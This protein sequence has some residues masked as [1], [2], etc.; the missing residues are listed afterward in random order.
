[1]C[2]RFVRNNAVIESRYMTTYQ[3]VIA[4][5]FGA[6]LMNFA[7]SFLNNMTANWKHGNRLFVDLLFGVV[8]L[9]LLASSTSNGY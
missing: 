6:Y 8:L 7:S 2:I 4:V 3:L 1:M 5:M 9:I